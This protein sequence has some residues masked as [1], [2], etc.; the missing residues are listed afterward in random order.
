MRSSEWKQIT[1]IAQHDLT[2]LVETTL[3]RIDALW[4]FQ[5]IPASGRKTETKM[6]P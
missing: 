4:G 1:S 2:Q 6:A 5:P 3:N